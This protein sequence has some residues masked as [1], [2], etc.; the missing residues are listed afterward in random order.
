MRNTLIVALSAALMMAGCGSSSSDPT[1]TFKKGYKP[2]VDGFAQDSHAI[3]TGIE[4][5]SGQT[6]L[7]LASA[8]QGYASSWQR[9]LSALEALKPPSSLAATFTTLSAAATRVEADLLRVVHALQVHSSSEASN[10]TAALV[11]DILAAKSAA[12]VINKK[13]GVT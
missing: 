4:H 12:S 9:H 11:R 7:Q 1:A 10:S 8:F 2:V 3:G 13:L 5:A 6:D